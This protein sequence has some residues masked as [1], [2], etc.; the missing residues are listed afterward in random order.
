LLPSRE[1]LG[2]TTQSG[3]YFLKQIGRRYLVTVFYHA[4]VALIYTNSLCQF[5]LTY[6]DYRSPYLD[7]VS[8]AHN[9]TSFNNLLLV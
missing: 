4:D 6:F 9:L 3:G 8:D 7:R 1:I 2:F 5:Y